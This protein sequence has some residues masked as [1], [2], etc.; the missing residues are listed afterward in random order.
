MMVGKPRVPET[1]ASA[2]MPRPPRPKG[3]AAGRD[4]VYRRTEGEPVFADL[5]ALGGSGDRGNQQLGRLAYDAVAVVVLGHP[6]GVGN[7]VGR[8]VT[9]ARCSRG[10]RPTAGGCSR[11]RTGRGLKV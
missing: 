9:R 4:G 11:R 10:S 6:V 7:R 3:A 1:P 8:S 2:A 5:D